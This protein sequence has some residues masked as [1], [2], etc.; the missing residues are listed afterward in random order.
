M[1]RHE[2]FFGGISATN[3]GYTYINGIITDMEVSDD[4]DYIMADLRTE[5][6]VLVSLHLLL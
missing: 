5:L 6:L 3:I 2:E 4:L 1:D